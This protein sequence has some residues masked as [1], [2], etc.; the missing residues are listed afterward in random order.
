[1]ESKKTCK[2]AYEYKK[3]YEYSKTYEYNKKVNRCTMRATNAIDSAAP[4]SVWG[5]GVPGKGGITT[6]SSI[7]ADL[8]ASKNG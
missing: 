3:A 2:R 6:N 5:K 7:Q 1:M 8:E 4:A